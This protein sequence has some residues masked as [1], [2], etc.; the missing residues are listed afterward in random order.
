MITL[1][2]NKANDKTRGDGGKLAKALKNNIR[3]YSPINIL[4]GF[5][6]VKCDL[7]SFYK[8]NTICIDSGIID[9][10][11]DR[12]VLL[13]SYR[14]D[15]CIVPAI[16]NP[17][18]HEIKLEYNPNGIIVVFLSNS[19]GFWIKNWKKRLM[20]LLDIL[21]QETREVQFKLHP[22]E[23]IKNKRYIKSKGYS[24]IK[25]YNPKDLFCAVVQGGGSCYNLVKQGIP[26]FCF[27]DIKYMYLCNKVSNSDTNFKIDDSIFNQNVY[28][29]FVYMVDKHTI[30]VNELEKPDIFEFLSKEY[31]NNSSC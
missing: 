25:E 5:A 4:I 18:K 12:R 8:E 3:V 17:V 2:G 23:H 22:R 29:D 31:L 30:N 6:G 13:N 14:Y 7:C 21:K 11:R 9:S 24:I 20:K 10:I 15:T 16:S 27:D 1:I 19:G 28:S 26:L